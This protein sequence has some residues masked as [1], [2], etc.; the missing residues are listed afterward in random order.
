MTGATP[1]KW[2]RTWRDRSKE[3][4]ELVPVEQDAAGRRPARHLDG[5]VRLPV[6]RDGVHFIPLYEEV[7]VAVIG[8]E[9][10]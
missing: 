3:R 2:A 4:L 9:A 7:P 1:D 6:D 8:I 10:R 5:L